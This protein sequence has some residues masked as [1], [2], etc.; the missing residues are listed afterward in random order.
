VEMVRLA[1]ILPDTSIDIF[2][3][4]IQG[5]EL[6]A[7]RGANH[8]LKEIPLVFTEVE[9]I[10]LYQNQPLFSDLE[11]FLRSC[12]FR[13]YNLYE[14]WTHPDGQLTAGD[15]LFINHRFYKDGLS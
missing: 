5:Y 4:D 8:L 11:Q 13:L 14:L 1:D 15:A 2:K 6:E 12:G 3:L 9:F 10:P 7:L